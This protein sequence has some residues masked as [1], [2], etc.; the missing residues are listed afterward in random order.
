MKIL[1]TVII[2]LLIG[3]A[4]CDRERYR[5]EEKFSEARKKLMAAAGDLTKIPARVEPTGE[6]SIKGKIAVFNKGRAAVHKSELK[7]DG[8]ADYYMNPLYFREMGE[9]YAAAPEEVGTA[10]VVE[11]RTQQKGVYKTE[12]GRE[13]PATVEDCELTLIDRTTPAVVF[14]R[15]FEKAPSPERKAVGNTVATQSAQE[16]VSQ[17]LKVLPRR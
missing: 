11:C 17:F 14:R 3:L 7:G 8:A 1:T 2:F 9:T 16:D 15:K 4:A 12:D 10:A 5:A 13:L 6:P